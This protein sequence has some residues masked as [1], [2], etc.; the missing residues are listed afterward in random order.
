MNGALF[1]AI[2][3]VDVENYLE[4]EEEVVFGVARGDTTGATMSKLCL[5]I[6]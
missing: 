1:G 4:L 2:H 3:V 5:S 6:Y